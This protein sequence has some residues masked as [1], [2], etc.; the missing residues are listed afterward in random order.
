MASGDCSFPR[1]GLALALVVATALMCRVATA[2]DGTV[3]RAV[4][5]TVNTARIASDFESA[6]SSK[7]ASTFTFDSGTKSKAAYP[8]KSPVPI[9]MHPASLGD[10]AKGAAS[11]TSKGVT[12]SVSENAEPPNST[13][14]ESEDGYVTQRMFD[15]FTFSV[16]GTNQVFTTDGN[17]KAV[18]AAAATNYLNTFSLTEVGGEITFGYAGAHYTANF[19]CTAGGT[20]CVTPAQAQTIVDQ[21]IVCAFEGQCVDNGVQFTKRP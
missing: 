11:D 3:A 9:F 10:F 4:T 8:V 13:I 15:G 12:R 7:S 2:Q 20:D 18:T 21:L 1:R 6:R 14:Y 19:E 16:R 17:D 5:S